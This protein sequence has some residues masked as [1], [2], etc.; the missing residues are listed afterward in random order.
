MV[1]EFM[2]LVFTC[3]PSESYR[4]DSGLLLLCLCDVFRTMNSIN[5]IITL[6]QYIM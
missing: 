1:P 3:M 2:Y 5:Y 6:Q 4:S